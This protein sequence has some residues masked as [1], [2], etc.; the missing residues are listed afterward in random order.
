[1][2]VSQSRIEHVFTVGFPG[3][4]EGK[5]VCLQCGRPGFDPSVGKNPWRRKWQP[6]PVFLPGKFHG[7]RSLVGYSPWG[8][9]DSDF[10]FHC[11]K[12]ISN[13]L[14]H[15]AEA[16]FLDFGLGDELPED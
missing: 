7:W 9:K 16:P 15:R 10:H 11:G 4:L 14:G 2:S 13:D 1:M 6:T 3:G 8:H 5:R 12:P